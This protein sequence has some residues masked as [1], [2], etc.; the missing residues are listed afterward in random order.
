MKMKQIPKKEAAEQ[1]TKTMEDLEKQGIKF[2]I[3]WTLG[4]YDSV[5]IIEA[6]SEKEA[7][8]IN[9]MFQGLVRTETMT[10]VPREEA[11]KLL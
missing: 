6:P 9:L 5:A 4:R 2:Q 3:Y 1:A 8:K 10:A 7:M 11:I